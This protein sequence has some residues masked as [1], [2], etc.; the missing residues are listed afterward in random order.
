MKLNI[1]RIL[2]E[3]PPPQNTQIGVV[4]HVIKKDQE[5]FRFITYTILNENENSK[6]SIYNSAL[7][8]LVMCTC[9][10]I[11]TLVSLKLTAL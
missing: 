5:N 3:S 9:I 1:T 4:L 7:N 6:V 8:S 11:R 10:Y 2:H